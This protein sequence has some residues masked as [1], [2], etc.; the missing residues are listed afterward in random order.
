MGGLRYKHLGTVPKSIGL[1]VVFTEFK[2]ARCSR[3][4][5]TQG[6]PLRDGEWFYSVVIE[7]GDD[8]TRREYSAEAWTGP[9][10]GT[11]GWWKGRMPQ[12]GARKLVL[13][14][15]PVLVDVLRG[16][17]DSENRRQ[18]RYLLALMLLRR[19]VVSLVPAHYSSHTTHS[20]RED[21]SQKGLDPHDSAEQTMTVKVNAD[22]SE[23]TV[24]VCSISQ[25]DV[26]TLEAALQELLYCE[27]SD[28]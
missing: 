14:P 21:Q 5:F 4:C 16:L 12:A 25:R 15:D 3:K 20:A 18:L 8:L 17:D 11:V 22:H 24:A 13:A 26:E 9:P 23:I 2:V 6:R 1:L 7:D 19:R 27:A 28:A 10:E